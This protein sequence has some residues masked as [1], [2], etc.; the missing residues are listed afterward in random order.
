MKRIRTGVTW[1]VLVVAVTAPVVAAWAVVRSARSQLLPE[2]PPA[3]VRAEPAAGGIEVPAALV[4]DIGR[5]QPAPAPAWSGLV[6][7]VL[8]GPGD[9]ITT[10]TPIARVGGALRIASGVGTPIG[11]TLRRGDAGPDVAS[12]HQTLTA[13]GQPASPGN[14][15]GTRTEAGVRR[16]SRQL[17]GAEATV[18]D[19]G[20]LIFLPT[21]DG[22]VADISLGLGQPAPSSGAAV[23]TLAPTVRGGRLV[24]PADIPLGLGEPEPGSKQSPAAF[25]LDSLPTS[26]TVPEG[27]SF[28]ARDMEMRFIDGGRLDPASFAVA[29]SLV[30]GGVVIDGILRRP[31]PPRTAQVPTASVF[32]GP[33]GRTCAHLRVG[34]GAPK[35]VTVDVLDGY[36]GTT[37][38]SGIPPRAEVQLSP[39]VD[40]RRQCR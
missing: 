17:T 27:S 39:A 35:T 22:V 21:G 11:R 25:S 20:W 28:V 36:L 2:L 33:T 30:H 1:L 31:V 4:L 6:E 12:L 18:F 8:I 29:A 10:G 9:R 13:L 37:L 15:F 34:S 38:A 3:W 19:P 7:E 16:L 32:V 26:L 5:P 40:V 14:V 24:A 23:V